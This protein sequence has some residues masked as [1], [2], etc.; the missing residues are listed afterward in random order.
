MKTVTMLEFR[1]EAEKILGR[2]QKGEHMI[3]TYRGKPAARLRVSEPM[4]TARSARP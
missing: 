1:Q 3:L 4:M 2:I